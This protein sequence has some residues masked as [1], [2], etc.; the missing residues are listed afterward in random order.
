M[1]PETK[2]KINVMR[3]AAKE[4]VSQEERDAW[5]KAM[6]ALIERG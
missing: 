6:F 5:V 3:K 2:S 4:A 1:R